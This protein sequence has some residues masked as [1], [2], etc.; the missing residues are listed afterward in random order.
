MRFAD[1][2]SEKLYLL[3]AKKY[4]KHIGE[5]AWDGEQ[6]FSVDNFLYARCC[7][8]ANG[9]NL[10]KKVLNNPETMPKDITFEA[11]L[12]LPSDAYER[13]TG[14]DYDYIPAFNFETY[15]NEE[16]WIT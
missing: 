3:D 10:Y 14:K 16:G 12:Y 7:V 8:V 1:L 9:E 15:S 4:A 6:Y 5:D 11:L 13:K 2:L